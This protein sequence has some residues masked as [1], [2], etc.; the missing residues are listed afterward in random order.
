MSKPDKEV[1]DVVMRMFEQ[2]GV[3]HPDS[4]SAE[5]IIEHCPNVPAEFTRQ[6]VKKRDARKIK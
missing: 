5:E 6:H 1:M 2:H 4:F 3:R